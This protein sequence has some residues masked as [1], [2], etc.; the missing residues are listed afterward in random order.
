MTID[1]SKDYLNGL[2]RELCKLPQETE[3]VEF[4]HNNDNPDEI[5][6]YLSALANSA[7]LNGKANAYLLWGIENDTHEII[8]TTFS[9][10]AKKIGG[11]EIE[12]WLL[13]LLSPKIYFRFFEF[14]MDGHAIVLLE[15]GQA[16]RHPVQFKQQEFIRVGSYKKKLKD[17]PEKERELWR[18][19]DAMPFEKQIAAEHVSDDDVLRL[20]DYPAYFDLFNLPLPGSKS[21]LLQT[22]TAEELTVK[23]DSGTW[24]ITN[25]GAMLFAKKLSE[26]RTLQRK[27]VRVIVYKG[28]S[29][30]ETIRE[31]VGTKGYACG[32]EGLI[33]FINAL[34]PSNEVI[35]R[36]LRKTVQMYP[37]LAIRELVANAL[38]HQDFFIPGAGPMI[39][40]FDDRMEITNPGKPLV[41]TQR[42][43]DSP[44][45]SRNES[46]ASFMRRIGV[47][48][49]RGS[50]VDKVVFQTE[51]YQLPAPL[52]EVIG[53]NT[54]AILFAPR[55][56][57]RMDKTDRNRACYL[58][59]CL[60]YVTREYMT[61]ASLRERFGIEAAHSAII[62]RMIKDV[63]EAGLIH[64]H[65]ESA[66]RK[67]MKYVPFWA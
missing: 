12:N 30:V 15:I 4:K 38:I 6:E 11:E 65:D 62:S 48:E 29:R 16:F 33:G 3:W 58:H 17:Y 54:R 22:L 2:I 10:S 60:K 46:I 52:F 19:F 25:V 67:F 56:L 27:A 61:N 35:E 20:L 59:A 51:F 66:S 26:F 47:C 53:D 64:S 14:E 21:A 39:E 34:L 8:G 45:R 1:R 63:V 9:P 32:F 7:A 24:N 49:E 44:P 57:K 23:T 13:R 18:I 28:N 37:E 36:A 31:Q 42:F 41:D 40:I 55:P 50:G 43:L 5:G